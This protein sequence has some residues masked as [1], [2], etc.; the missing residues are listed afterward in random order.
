MPPRPILDETRRILALAWPVALT[1]LHWTVLSVTD[2]VLVGLTGTDQVAAFG[3]S[4]AVTLV[5]IVGGLAWLSGVLVFSARADGAG[6]LPG[7]GTTLREGVL[8]ALVLGSGGAVV[9]ALFASALLTGI[10]VAPLLI[11]TATRVV[12][13]MALC[14]PLQ[15]LSLAAGFFLEG[16]ARPRRVMV[17]QLLTLPINAALAWR[18]RAGISVCRRGGPSARRRRPRWPRRLRRAGYS[19]PCGPRPIAMPADCATFP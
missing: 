8:L 5:T 9:L 10:G 14:L 6:D 1:S 19:S 2:I 13:V 3:A 12:Q 11:P 17:V 15:L 16:I 7:T 4:R 18:G